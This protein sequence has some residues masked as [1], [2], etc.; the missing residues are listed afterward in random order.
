MDMSIHFEGNPIAIS[1]GIIT[2]YWY[3][4]AYFLGFGFAYFIA[5]IKRHS[6]Q[7]SHHTLQDWLNVSIFGV[8]IGGR[9]G[10][11]LLYHFDYYL[12]N[13]IKIFFIWEGGMALEVMKIL[14]KVSEQLEK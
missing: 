11:V 2:I 12:K 8:T 10:Y 9:L 1:F 13:P 3:A 6:L 5:Y 7:L 4:I 14:V